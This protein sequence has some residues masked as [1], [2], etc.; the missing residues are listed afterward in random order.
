MSAY[1]KFDSLA[2]LPHSAPIFSQGRASIHF[3]RK[4]QQ[5]DQQK[6]AQRF[7]KYPL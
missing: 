3:S 1:L 2:L 4:N 7:R 6:E 5:K